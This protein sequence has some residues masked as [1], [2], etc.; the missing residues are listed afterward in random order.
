MNRS[1]LLPPAYEVQRE[2]NVFSLRV[3][4]MG[5]GYPSLWFQVPSLPLVP[6]PFWGRD[7]ST[8]VSGPRSSPGG[9]GGGYPSQ[10]LNQGGRRYPSQVLE[11]TSSP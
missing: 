9:R 8:P 4:S 2:G 10:V 11:I 3:C 7:G 6:G 1:N 5:S